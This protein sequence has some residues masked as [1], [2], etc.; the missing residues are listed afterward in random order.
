M[1]PSDPSRRNS[2]ILLGVFLI[3]AL[4][5]AGVGYRNYLDQKSG[6]EAEMRNQLAAIAD[7][8]VRQVVTWR[9]ERL[10]DARIIAGAE[11]I[12]AIRQ[13]LAGRGNLEGR[14][15]IVTWIQ[16]V[17]DTSGYANAVL[18]N[19]KGK[20]CLAVGRAAG[21]EEHYAELANPVLLTGEVIFSDFHYDEGLRGPHLGLNIPLRLLPDERPQGALLLGIDPHQFLYP[22][23]QSWPTPSRT[24]ETLL[25]RREGDQILYLSELRHR[26]DAAMT[27]R[28]PLTDSRR[29]A[30]RAVLGEEGIME[31]ID[32]RGVPVL[33]AVRKVPGSPWVLVAKMDMAEI[34]APIRQQAR[35]LAM[36]VFSLTLATG[37]VVGLVWRD[38][39]SRFY[40]QKYEAELE[41]RRSRALLNS[42]IEGTPDAVYVKD[43][44]GR[45]LLA[46]SATCKATGMRLEEI[47]GRDDTALFPPD[48]A[49]M[50][51]D[52]D[53]ATTAGG[54]MQTLEE[55]VTFRTGEAAT[56][57]TAKGPLVDD[58]GNVIGL[59]GI[60]RD[61]TDRKRSE[62]ERARLQDQL[63][64]AQK[65]ESIGRL[66]GGVAH[67]FNNLLTVING[68]AALVLA[69][70]PQA[71]S[72][73][74]AVTE[75]GL[76]GER[77]ADLTQQLLAFSRKQVIEPKLVDLN[78]VV[79]DVTKMLERLVG[80]DVKVVTSLAA[81]LGHVL[82]DAGQMHQVL[83]NLAV[84][85][86][87]AM[88]SGG[89][90]LIE[91]ANLEID[92]DYVTAHADTNA[93]PY[94]ML[95]VS[96]N[97]VGMDEET[98]QHAFEPFFT[99]K[100]KGEGTGLGLSTVYGIVKQSGGWIWLYSE[101]NR[102]TTFKIYLPRLTQGAAPQQAVRSVSS[103]LQGTETILVVE[104][105][106]DVRKLTAKVLKR[107]GY[108]VLEAANGGEALL[109]C[110]RFSD[111]IHV[112]ITDVVMP[113]M[114]GPEL[115]DRLAPLRPAMKVLYISGYT[116]EA[117]GH[118]GV[119]DPGVAY[120]SK[121]FP[122]EALAEKVRE[123][124]NGQR[125]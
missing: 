22:L 8:K 78:Q 21:P 29:P 12:P 121:P 23:M 93:G 74:D 91:T 87:H 32:Y 42:I 43:K 79:R 17:R 96:D 6:I 125:S 62:E 109:A 97:G 116:A 104:D 86:R 101:Q 105:Q 100:A 84:N 69:Q 119:M 55:H 99:T 4:A 16:T 98:R 10:A 59:F 106:P 80:E 60:A 36:I 90:L 44:Q 34:Y 1:K 70:L 31:G 58:S 118:Q 26:N 28:C 88:P 63:Q 123:L 68:Y 92:A 77:A 56:Y 67:D 50:V 18:M 73:R 94:A 2:Y 13:M 52:N 83:M 57:L 46:N 38:W 27:L 112:M 102:G 81:S 54:R 45:Y 7:L 110:E 51:M 3:L 89:E 48:V 61:I 35:W 75:I 11:I 53:R 107:Y 39:R 108:R 9:K 114:T 30:V 111:S 14:E 40:Q 82:V 113:G 72:L 95:A 64:Q 41:Q 33:A 122:P 120:L 76:A 37:A 115:A 71:D 117:I 19:S 20:M 25:A 124:L 85:A 47:L 24:A 66:A 103:S 5:I 65:M 49:Q 15:Q